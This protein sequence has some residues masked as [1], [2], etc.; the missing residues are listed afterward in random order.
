M[1]TYRS[2]TRATSLRA[3]PDQALV[4]LAGLMLVAAL[5]FASVPAHSASPAAPEQGFVYTADEHGNSLSM[6]DLSSGQVTSVDVTIAPHNL[7]I[8]ADRRR[9]FATGPLAQADDAH[10]HGN[11][12][13]DGHGHGDERGRLLVFDAHDLAAGPLADIE[14]GSHPA[15]VVIDQAGELAFVTNA[16]DATVSVVDLGASAVIETITTGAYPHG[17][18]LSPDGGE[19]YVANVLD[20][21]ISV[22]DVEVLAEVARI[23]VGQAPVQVGFVPD[24]SRVYVSLRDEN[25]VAVIDTAAREVIDRIAVGR[26]PIQVYATPDGREVYVAN[27]GTRDNPDDTVSVIDVASS[28]VVATVTTDAGAHG[29]VASPDG[30]YVFVSNI[31]ANSVS[32]IDTES[33]EVVAGFAVG[34]GP[35]GIT[36]C[37]GT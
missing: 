20:G 1:S 22:I 8:S 28:R 4:V 18:R 10:G 32:A 37:A 2:F 14:V 31:Y 19:L 11:G 29:V 24:G 13:G 26:G 7:Q 12:H 34:R 35:N 3:T 21:S 25:A 17:L 23:P 16:E 30:R 36:F 6:I 9:L 33:Y 27:E 15:H 5:V